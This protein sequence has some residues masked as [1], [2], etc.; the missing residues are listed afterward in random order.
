M[1]S[2]ST[3]CG[4]QGAGGN[5]RAIRVTKIYLC[6]MLIRSDHKTVNRLAGDKSIHN[7]EDVGNRDA[8]IEKVIGFD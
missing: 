1:P 8:P 3:E 4:L 2:A 7:L 5:T 6:S